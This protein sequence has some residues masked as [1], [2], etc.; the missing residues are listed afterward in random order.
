MIAIDPAHWELIDFQFT[1][2]RVA[3][4]AGVNVHLYDIVHVSLPEAK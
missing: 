1:A 4:P 3:H 2:E